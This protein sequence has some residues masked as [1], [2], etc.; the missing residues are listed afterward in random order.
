MGH[1]LTT[2]VGGDRQDLTF[3]RRPS[4][5]YQLDAFIQA[6]KTGTPPLTDGEDAVKQMMVIDQCY[7]A[8]GLPLRGAAN[9]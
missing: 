6:V 8:A 3:D 5:S 2:E 7:M 4:Y 1:R 9:A